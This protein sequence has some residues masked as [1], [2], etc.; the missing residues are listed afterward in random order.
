MPR[1]QRKRKVRPTEGRDLLVPGPLQTIFLRVAAHRRTLTDRCSGVCSMRVRSGSPPNPPSPRLVEIVDWPSVRRPEQLIPT[2]G[3]KIWRVPCQSRGKIARQ[4]WR[5]RHRRRSRDLIGRLH[6]RRLSGSRGSSG[7]GPP[8]VTCRLVGVGRPPSHSTR[9]GPPPMSKDYLKDRTGGPAA[10][11]VSGGGVR[12][13]GRDRRRGARGHVGHGCGGGLA[14]HGGD[15]AVSVSAL[16]G[17]RGRHQPDRRAVRL[18]TRRG[19]WPWAAAV[20]VRRQRV[21]AS[22]GSG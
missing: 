17:P 7:G 2:R 19:R 21:R 16:A 18:G 11:G 20:P 10:S 8:L 13:E 4:G 12:G 15:D 3:R 14:G 22:G 5:L 9:R 1:H 6:D